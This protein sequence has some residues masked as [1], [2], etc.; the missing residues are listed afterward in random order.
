MPEGTTFIKH[1]RDSDSQSSVYT[2]PVTTET[3]IHG[4]CVPFL[5]VN[6]L[7]RK[8]EYLPP[9]RTEVTNVLSYISV[10]P[11]AFMTLTGATFTL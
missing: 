2:T 7:W 9:S 6:Q 4:Y 11:Y 3:P 5:G 1:A 8:A 10:I